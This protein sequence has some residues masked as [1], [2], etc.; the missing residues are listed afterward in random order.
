MVCERTH[1]IL[2]GFS[3]SNELLLEQEFCT[4]DWT[5]IWRICKAFNY[6]GQQQFE[7]GLIGNGFTITNNIV[8][9]FYELNPR[10]R[11]LPLSVKD[12]IFF[13][14]SCDYIVVY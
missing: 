10:V 13:G 8:R 11:H 1:Y 5:F 14:W 4:N 3:H 7:T 2:K 6:I 12:F 9:R